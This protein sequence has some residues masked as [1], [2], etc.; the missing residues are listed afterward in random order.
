MIEALVT[1]L[2]PELCDTLLELV[3][4]EGFAPAVWHDVESGLCRL[5]LYPD[6]AESASAVLAALCGGARLLGL[7]LE[8]E[9]TAIKREEWA[10]SWK[11]FFK[12]TR[13]SRRIVVRP[14]WE[15]Y[16]VQG[17]ERVI[18]LDPG[19]SFGTGRHATTQ[20]CLQFLDRLAWEDSARQVL[21]MGCGSGILAIGAALL[22]FN[23]V[24]GFDNDPAAIAV[25]H[26]N[27]ALNG[28]KAEFVLADIAQPQPPVEVVVA[29]ILAPVLIRYAPQ[30]VEAL[31][32]TVGARL[33][34]SGILADQ[35][36]A[37]RECYEALGLVEQE[38]LLLEEWR[39][40]MFAWRAPAS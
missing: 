6:S 24:R 32:C 14:S 7:E 33:V 11:R 35:Y 10:E 31:Q 29:N 2:P 17:D 21:D 27:A 16:Q 4:C 5:T 12:V 20:S 36:D 3:D 38:S 28:V 37:V 34:L 22:G 15:E 8:F 23:S 9:R 30:V 13:V 40:G 19:L 25:A 26:E 39:S 18:T 1:T